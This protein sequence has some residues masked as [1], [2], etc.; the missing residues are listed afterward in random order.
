MPSNYLQQSES[1]NDVI[2]IEMKDI[3]S[4]RPH[5]IIRSGNTIFFIVIGLLVTLTFFIYYPDTV[6]AS[7]RLVALNAPKHVVVKSEGKLEKL[8]VRNEEQV[9]M[10]QP[11][12]YLQST[13]DHEQVLRLKSW[14]T[15]LYVRI[16]EGDL[17]YLQLNPIP[18]LN[19]LGELQSNYQEL[20]SGWHETTQILASGYYEKR[21]Y[22]LQ[23][24][25]KYLSELKSRT[26]KQKSLIEQDKQLQSTEYAAYEKLA[27]EKVIAPLELNQYKSKL[28]AKEQDVELVNAQITN[29][30]LTTHNKRKELLDLRKQVQDQEQKFHS[31]LLNL[32]SEI[33]KWE[34]QY[35]LV[36]PEGGKVIFMSFLQENQLLDSGQELFYVQSSNSNVYAELMVP[37]N[38]LGKVNL[39]QK[40]LI[41]TE[42]YP[43]HEYGRLSGTISYIT[44]FPNRRDSFLVSVELTNG[45][46]TNYQKDVYFRNNLSAKAQI[47]T[48]NRTLF[49]RFL[50]KLRKTFTR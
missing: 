14:I 28:L 47:I 50:G 19:Q 44:G 49:D 17:N 23:K 27:R 32:K 37:Q 13:A 42:S 43:V 3:V 31:L 35:I 6:N 1:D 45:L 16:K 25:L 38:G 12:A 15:D 40:V 29:S 20:Q 18:E 9:N 11:L 2:S 33:E 21:K 48:E 34:Q 8:L 39:G 5:W 46:K 41:H 7:A 24:D 36:A 10:G 22:A 4:H 26:E 30:D